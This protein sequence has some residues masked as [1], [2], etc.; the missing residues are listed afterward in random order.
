MPEIAGKDM[1]YLTMAE[2][3]RDALREEM[4]RD[5]TV[6]LI[7]EDIGVFGGSF[8]VTDGLINEFGERRVRETPVS[9][10]AIIGAAVGAAL[11]GM[12]PVAEI[13]YLDFIASAMDQ[14]VNQAAKI[15]LMSGGK[16]KVPLVIRAAIGANT[17]GAQHAQ[18][19]EA[20]F[21]HTPGLKVVIPSTPYDA[22]GLLKASIRDDNPVIF[23][24]HK[25]LYGSKPA[26]AGGKSGGEKVRIKESFAAVP[27]E[28]YL[29]PLGKGDIKQE[30][31]DVTVIATSLMVHRVLEASEELKKVGIDL[32]VID[33]RTLVPFDKEIVVRSVKKT[34][35]AVVVSEDNLTCGVSAEIADIIME[36]AFDFLD[37]PV[38]R[39][40]ALDTPVPFAPIAESYV[41]PGVK[42]IRDE[43]MSLF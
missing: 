7:G 42:R 1:K 4:R 39:I 22:K 25:Y 38:K 15:R 14:V 43:I 23:L 41:I 12:R 28:E 11:T 10:S 18:C 26:S 3:I 33:P 37:A 36:E 24:E 34:G 20:W 16:A 40:A 35:K 30:G 19:L 13:M 17:H 27:D 8:Q 31:D 29:I 5:K 32:E 6:F 2:A 9:E 21:M